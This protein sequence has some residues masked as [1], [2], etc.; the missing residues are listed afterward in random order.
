MITNES[1]QEHTEGDRLLVDTIY[2]AV[3]R[4][5]GSEGEE[6]AASSVF[7]INLS[8]GDTRRPFTRVVSP[9]ARLVD[10]LSNCYNVLFLVSGGNVPDPLKIQAFEHWSAFESAAPEDRQRAVIAALNSAKHERTILSPAEALNALTIGAQHHDN[11][12]IRQA[13]ADGQAR[14]IS[15]RRARAR[16]NAGNG[17]PAQSFDRRSSASVRLKCRSS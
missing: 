4:I 11:L 12:T 14:F 8:L 6:A 10:F 17:R 7:L 16:P 3:L 2:R 1:G 5:K 13:S 15:A 9:L